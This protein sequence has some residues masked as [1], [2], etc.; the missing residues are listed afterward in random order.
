MPTIA[1]STVHAALARAAEHLLSAAGPDGIVSRKDVRAKLLS[2][3]GPERDLVDM[4]YRFIDTRDSARSARVTKRDIDAQLAHI[5][6]E[7]V[8]RYDLDN[9]GLSEDEVARMSD[10]G[11]LAVT[12]ARTLKTATAPADAATKPAATAPSAEATGLTGE[13][14]AQKIGSLASGLFLDDFGSE[15]GQRLE[16]FHAAAKLSQLTRETF[17]AALSL[18]DRPEH[19]IVRFE[20]ADRCLGRLVHVAEWEERRA[21]GEELV[22]FMKANLREIKAL[23]LGKD[24]EEMLVSHP[25]YVVGIDAAGNLVGL[26]SAVIWT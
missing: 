26:K 6:T 14:L 7:L 19:E 23:V 10:L 11:K 25:A 3:E 9:N 17:R 15:G 20:P 13:A 24:G 8:D 2:L 21:Q 1:T 12:L 16:A 18:T 5:K 22:Q 4:L